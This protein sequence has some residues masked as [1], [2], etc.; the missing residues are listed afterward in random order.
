LKDKNN[1]IVENGT[2][3]STQLSF[4]FV[5]EDEQCVPNEHN[6]KCVMVYDES[7]ALIN[8]VS[9][10]Y[11]DLYHPKKKKTFWEIAHEE[12]ISQDI[13]VRINEAIIILIYLSIYFF[14]S[15]KYQK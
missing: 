12:L 3:E 15:W 14:L 13:T 2:E 7:L 5:M 6:N 9:S 4:K 8:S 10:R 1:S 11:E